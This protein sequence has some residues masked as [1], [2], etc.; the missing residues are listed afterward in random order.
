[1][2]TGSRYGTA[3]DKV[4][5]KFLAVV[6]GYLSLSTVAI[7]EETQINS[8]S[9]IIRSVYDEAIELQD[10]YPQISISNKTCLSAV[11]SLY[12]RSSDICYTKTKSIR[13]R[14]D[15]CFRLS[16]SVEEMNKCDLIKTGA[17]K[18]ENSCKKEVEATYKRQSE[19]C[20]EGTNKEIDLYFA[21]LLAFRNSI[22]C[23]KNGESK[24]G[25][26][27]TIRYTNSD[28]GA[29]TIS[30]DRS[31]PVSITEVGLR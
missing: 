18:M 5:M 24:T 27:E 28:G 31:I 23:A 20:S 29:L 12:N 22:E 25:H 16:E 10:S 6:L 17:D 15:K 30:Y 26:I 1:M 14:Y 8:C 2:P 9:T 7:G 11:L 13:L 3:K 4:G 19:K 21:K